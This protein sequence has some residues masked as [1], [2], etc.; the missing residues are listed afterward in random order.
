MNVLAPLKPIGKGAGRD[1]LS[2]LT[3]CTHALSQHGFS[4]IRKGC[5]KADFSAFGAQLKAADMSAPEHYA[6]T[7][8]RPVSSSS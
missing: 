3:P 8:S 6:A 5:P 2:T 4:T 7:S 1:H